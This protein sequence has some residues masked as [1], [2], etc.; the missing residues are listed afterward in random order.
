[1][2]NIYFLLS[3]FMLFSVSGYSRN[4]PE[5]TRVEPV[6][7]RI[8]VFDG[9]TDLNTPL[10][11]YISFSYTIAN[12]KQGLLKN[13]VTYRNRGAMPEPGAPDNP[14]DERNRNNILDREIVEIRYYGDSVAAAIVEFGSPFYIIGWLT[15]EEGQWMNAGEDLDNSLENARGHADRK[16][17]QF[18]AYLGRIAVLKESPSDLSP[19][20]DYLKSN[21]QS[22]KEYL[23]GKLEKY[24]LV[25]CGE[26]HRR[27]ISWDLMKNVVLD[28]AFPENT[29]TVFMELPSWKQEVLDRFYNGETPDTGL[30]LDVMRAEQ[31]YG[32]WDG[33]EYEFLT[34]LWK[35]NRDLPDHKKIKVIAVDWQAPWDKLKTKEDLDNYYNMGVDRNSHMAEIIESHIT[36]SN[37]KRNNLF[38]VGFAH[39]EKSQLPGIASADRGKVAQQTAGMQLAG[40]LSEKNVFIVFPH[41]MVMNNASGNQGLLRNGIF[42][43]IFAENGNNPVGFDLKDSPF[44]K[45][46]YD[47]ND[48]GR[49]DSRAGTYEENFDGYLFFGPLDEEGPE[50]HLYDIFTDEFVKEI[51]RRALI[52]DD[53]NGTY[54]GIPVN[55]LTKERII[56]RLRQTGGKQNRWL[57]E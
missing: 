6:N 10:N 24:K 5:N 27:K 15:Y 43:R 20:V 51:Q 34:E 4:N 33:G 49:Y 40:R 53:E 1:M 37:D 39:A 2:K 28:P 9:K 55:E 8:A 3:I 57:P 47:A 45:E 12:G 14:V 23:L 25:I 11:S 42:D 46:P 29:G 35:I 36:N 30:L 48:P 32:W 38:I 26:V 7:K 17:K 50:Y 18:M 13:M 56:S 44:G 54:F 19:Y 41:S 21:G 31:V 22:P 52:L 16:S